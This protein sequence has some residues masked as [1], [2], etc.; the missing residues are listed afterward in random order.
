MSNQ[1]KYIKNID[2]HCSIS[3]TK[4]N[5]NI[6]NDFSPDSRT[7][8]NVT[9]IMILP[10]F[11]FFIPLVFIN[12]MWGF[13]FLTVLLPIISPFFILSLFFRN[14]T[15]EWILDRQSHKIIHN[16][17]TPS[18]KSLIQLSFSEIEYLIYTNY[19]WGGLTASEYS[20]KFH[21]KNMEEF[22]IFVGIKDNC[23]ELGIIIAEFMQKSVYKNISG[24]REK[25]L[26]S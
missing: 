14:K 6:F 5:L 16:Q 22:E 24:R 20:L 19:K 21:L 25:L 7:Y 17:L 23:E 15:E 1:E 8:R 12:F 18:K 3:M 2:I 13:I 4:K 11:L 10:I 9:V 26:P